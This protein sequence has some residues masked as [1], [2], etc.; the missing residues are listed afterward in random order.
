MRISLNEKEYL[1]LNKVLNYYK[2]SLLYKYS[3]EIELEKEVIEFFREMVG[4]YLSLFGFDESY[5]ANDDGVVLESLIDKLYLG[6]T[7]PQ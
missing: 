3:E 2:I 5:K 6:A 7:Q 1:V 4:N